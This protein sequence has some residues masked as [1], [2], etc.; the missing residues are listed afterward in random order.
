MI[1]NKIQSV[2][3]FDR[4]RKNMGPLGKYSEVAEGYYIFPRLEGP[5]GNRMVFQGKEVINWS[6]NDYLGL[7]RRQDVIETDAESAAEHGMGYPM[8]SRMMSGDTKWHE[9]LE[10]ELAS[11]VKKDKVVLM[12]FGYMGI[13]SAIDCLLSRRDVVIYDANSHAC[14]VDGV[15][16]HSGKRFAFT[17]NDMVSLEK[18]LGFA[19]TL[20]EKSGGGILVISEG[21]FGMQGDQGKLQEI[22]ELKKK[23]QFRFLVDDAHGFG[24]LG[25]T[26]AGAGE[27]QNVQQDIDLYFSTFAKS[28]GSI[29]AF[30]AGDEDIIKFLK[31][32]MRSQ[33]FAK[34]LP[35]IVVK[36]ALKRLD[37]MRRDNT[38]IK[39]LWNNVN[40]LQK[41]LKD[42][43]FNLGDTNS[44]VTP[45]FLNGSV[46][47]AMHLVHD[48]RENFS[49][50]C[51]IVVYPVI[52]QGMILLRLIP[53]ADHTVEDIEITIN[54]FSAISSKLNS[55]A[56][57]IK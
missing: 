12:N 19:T 8:G 28:M 42:K 18:Y 6:I 38:L 22:I 45:V 37:L 14:I 54:A 50:F 40:L 53:T 27:F 9:H 5:L 26:G 13:M 2:D 15:R 33:I 48:L 23:Y 46:E 31:Y 11:F 44:C 30:M 10:N 3:I 20:C 17:H 57:N 43:G 16:L 35:H 47:E 1:E 52:P 4:L 49:I 51:S 34:S 56:Y 41:G 7:A 32:N 36:G 25:E 39:K 24:T 21:V 29:G 55:G